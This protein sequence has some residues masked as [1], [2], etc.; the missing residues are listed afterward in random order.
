[1]GSMWRLEIDLQ[2]LSPTN[3]GPYKL[4]LRYMPVSKTTLQFTRSA[5]FS[6]GYLVVNRWVHLPF[7]AS[8]RWFGT[9]FLE[10]QSFE[11]TP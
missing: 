2:I 10:S 9:V 1:M 5:R 8:A 4:V 11:P 3:G 6:I 7:V